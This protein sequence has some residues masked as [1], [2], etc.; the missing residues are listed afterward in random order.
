MAEGYQPAVARRYYFAADGLDRHSERLPAAKHYDVVLESQVGT[1]G[2]VSV[3]PG[4]RVFLSCCCSLCPLRQKLHRPTDR[5]TDRLQVIAD[6]I[7]CRYVD[8]LAATTAPEGSVPWGTQDHGP[9]AA[10]GLLEPPLAEAGRGRTRE[11]DFDEITTFLET[12]RPKTRLDAYPIYVRQ[13]G[14]QAGRERSRETERLKDRETPA[15]TRTHAHILV[16]V[17]CDK[18]GGRDSSR[19]WSA[20]HSRSRPSMLQVLQKDLLKQLLA[21]QV[22]LAAGSP[23]RRAELAELRRAAA[24]A[25]AR[26]EAAEALAAAVRTGVVP[27]LQ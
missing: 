4:R 8:Y 13:A 3:S 18:K 24:E 21:K 22:E 17:A 5:P 27:Q 23:A 20:R 2:K 14:G 26:A 12:C 16:P 15:P 9:A 6:S 19:C 11:A 1:E 10:A 7:H 25:L